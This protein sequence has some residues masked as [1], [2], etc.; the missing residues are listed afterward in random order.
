MK[1]I[2]YRL[3][4]QGKKVCLVFFIFHLKCHIEEIHTKYDHFRKPCHHLG[5]VDDGVCRFA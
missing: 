3:P 5:D 4:F 2:K 1:I